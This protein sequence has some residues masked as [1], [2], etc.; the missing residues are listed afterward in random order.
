MISRGGKIVGDVA[1]M[2]IDAEDLLKDDET[3]A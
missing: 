2:M 3:A 1:D